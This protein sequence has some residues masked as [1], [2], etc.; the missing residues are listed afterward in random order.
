MR[1]GQ[2]LSIDLPAPVRQIIHTLEAAGHEAYAVGGCVRDSVLGRI[3]DDWDIT[4][5]A[6][7]REI[8]A[9]FSHTIDTGIQHGTVT[10]MLDH[11]GYELTTYRVDGEYL[12]GR[13]PRAVRYTPSL[14][15]D[16]K[17]RDFTINAMAYH[18]DRGLV[19]E[20][21]G[22]G[23]LKRKLVRCVGDPHQR[24]TEDALRMLRAVR[25]A[26]QLGFGLD[27]DTASAI[28]DLAENLKKVSAE[29][30]R[31]EL[32]KTI[33]SPHPACLE[34]AYELGLT[35]VFLPEF[36]ACMRTPQNTPHH[37]TDVG[38][39][40]LLVMQGVPRDPVL[41][42]AALLHDIAKPVCR[43]TDEKGVDHFKG[44]PKEGARMAGEILRRL[45]FDKDTT[46]RVVQLVR[47]HDERP[48][49]DL[50]SVRRAMVRVG[51]QAFPRLFALK[52]AD[53]LAQ[54]DYKREEK[55]G[56]IDDFERLREQILQKKEALSV[57][58]L[59]IS[60]RDLLEMGLPQGRLVGEVLSALLEDVLEEPEHNQADY[61]RKKSREILLNLGESPQDGAFS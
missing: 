39:H 27:A 34:M 40:T 6:R 47:Y 37:F 32:M 14:T 30:I 49:A 24:F 4:S 54:S 44:H 12:D 50:R 11:I 5:S 55:L 18:P 7:P 29:R 31:V 20:F 23:D 13:H 59:A 2:K 56:E 9:L 53:M 48:G 60:G 15:E 19:D 1:R 10:V 46:D 43:T 26:A 33:C 42:L 8:K 52:R 35:A 36:D 45:R 25:F 61:L 57:G 16:L 17:R 22:I 3:P 21:D 51:A 38:H 58:D 28:R 41:R